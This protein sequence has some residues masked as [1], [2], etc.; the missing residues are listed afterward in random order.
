[1]DYGLG[2]HFLEIIDSRYVYVRFKGINV[3]LG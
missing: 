2:Y 3:V 1:M